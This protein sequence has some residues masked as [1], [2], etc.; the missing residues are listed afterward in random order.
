MIHTYSDFSKQILKTSQQ[1]RYKTH[2]SVNR[3]QNEKSLSLRTKKFVR[4]RHTYYFIPL[5]I[6]WQAHLQ[7]PFPNLCS[8]AKQSGM[9]KETVPLEQ[10]QD[11]IFLH[12]STT[13]E[14]EPRGS[15]DTKGGSLNIPHASRTIKFHLLY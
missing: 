3:L 9:G 1:F 6:R 11:T 2:L 5:L 14:R 15:F 7:F 13:A 10:W 12:K 4:K 8:G